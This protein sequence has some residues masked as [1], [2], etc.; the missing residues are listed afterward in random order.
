MSRR[1]LAIGVGAAIL[2]ALAA[3][4]L[5]SAPSERGRGRGSRGG[6]SRGAGPGDDP[7]ALGVGA[8]GSDLDASARVS[9]RVEDSD[10]L[11]VTDGR[12]ILHCLRDGAAQSAPIPHGTLE[13]GPEGE[14]EGYG[15]RGV[16]CAELAHNAMIQGDAWVL[17]PGKPSTLIARPLGRREG[18]VVTRSGEPVPGARL[19]IRPLPG[20]RDPTAL[21]PFTS[22]TAL[23]DGDGVF[24]YARVERAPCDPCAEASGRCSVGE[25]RE[26]PTY[27]T[28]LLV[29]RAP[30]FRDS[31][32][33]VEIEGS[34]PWKVVM[35][36]PAEPIRGRLVDE[37]GAVYPRARILAR[38]QLRAY[39][40]HQAAVVDGAFE[41]GELG[42]GAYDL[43]A[44]QDGVEL[45]AHAGAVAGDEVELRGAPPAAGVALTLVVMNEEGQ[46]LADV[47]VDGG[48][49][50]GARTDAAGEVGADEVLAGAY[51]LLVRT[52]GRA[53]E[54]RSIVVSEGEPAVRVE[55]EISTPA[56]R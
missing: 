14:F 24:S 22:R 29:A 31:E 52:P 26:V 5:A 27:A 4:F 37:G 40:V 44:I 16:I 12:L 25:E 43:R 34:E 33:T 17:E 18:T 55:V 51:S 54:R 21:P 45:I 50:N 42:E 30:G 13:L 8:R 19:L 1:R 28:M 15:C 48:P 35:E 47:A 41:V 39:E 9:G 23:S 38:S 20:E 56:G 3:W 53:P 32:R 49:F 36:A 46:P 11:P 10:G 2:V 7:R 6:R